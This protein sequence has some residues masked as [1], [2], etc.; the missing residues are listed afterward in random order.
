M[1]TEDCHHEELANGTLAQGSVAPG[2][3]Q[4][5]ITVIKELFSGG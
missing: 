2:T 1:I 4:H 5:A 3:R